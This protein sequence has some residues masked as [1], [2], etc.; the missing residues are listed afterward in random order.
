MSRR[1]P[2]RTWPAGTDILDRA[3]A[4]GDLPA[5]LAPGTITNVV[6][7]VIWY[8]L[9]ATGEPLGDR[10]ADE[11]TSALTTPG[12]HHAAPHRARRSDHGHR[13]RV[14]RQ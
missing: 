4:R 2:A 9:L 6:F 3:R 12:P 10:L 7:G 11:V 5:Q 14:R 1:R 8:R 13:D